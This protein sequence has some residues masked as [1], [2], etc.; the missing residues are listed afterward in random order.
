MS[1]ETAPDEKAPDEA[2]APL[3][4]MKVVAGVVAAVVVLFIGVVLVMQRLAS[5]AHLVSRLRH[6][7]GEER[8]ELVMR[9]NLARGDVVTPMIAAL[10]DTSGGAEFRAEMIELLFKKNARAADELIEKALRGALAD[11]EPRVRA[12]AV[13]GFAVYMRGD[14][15]L[16]VLDLID[17][18]DP[19]VRR[20]VYMLL[21]YEERRG[22]RHRH[23][24]GPRGLWDLVSEDSR[25]DLKEKVLG[26]TRRRATGETDVELRL[27][28]RAVVGREVDR[29][30][31]EA[32][33]AAQRSDVPRAEELFRSALEL[34]PESHL[35][36]VRFVRHVL[37][38]GERDRALSLAEEYGA[39]L[40][41]PM[42]PSAPVIDGDPTDE[43][44]GKAFSDALR[45]RSSSRWVSMPV[46]GRSEMRIGHRDGKI[47]VA[48]VAYEDDLTRLIVKHK[49]RDSDVWY[50]DCVQFMFDPANSAR[51]AYHIIINAGGVCRDTHEYRR[52]RN[53]EF[54][55]AIAIFEDRGYWACELAVAA[56]EFGDADI[57]ADSIW[58]M[59]IVR[60]RIGAAEQHIWWPTY[61]RSTN[62]HLHPLA[63]FEFPEG[64]APPPGEK[65]DSTV[66]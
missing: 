10:E 53:F 29:L 15:R 26:A 54:D 41:V 60:T 52:E 47:H 64:A 46:E 27:L 2:G 38:Q 63:V 56:S 20:Q 13:Y 62:F 34:D 28:A 19:E 4:R 12:A 30:C 37:A 31:D 17:D 57:T 58:G 7:K 66:F 25:A 39:L 43:V 44:W 14:K 32:R 6:A 40:R 21:N 1:D 49:T 36:K 55:S 18:A 48:V 23:R 33:E 51:P 16:P 5:P 22:R 50:D 9:L 24:R 42:L 61:G 3:R 45:Y 65:G 59:N 11:S 35:A 8:E